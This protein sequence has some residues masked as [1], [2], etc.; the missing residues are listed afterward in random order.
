MTI[1]Q[2]IQLNAGGSMARLSILKMSANAHN[3]NRPPSKQID[4]RKSRYAN[5]RSSDFGLNRGLNSGEPIWYTNDGEQF[6]NERYC[7]EVFSSIRHTGW[8]SDVHCDEKI[9]GIVAMLP[10]NRF[11]AGY[12]S[13]CN[14]E[15][16]YFGEVFTDENDA[17]RMA[18]EHARISA[19]KEMEYSQKFD[20]ANNLSYE[21]DEE[22]SR[23]KEC[24]ALRNDP[25]FRYVRDSI[26]ECIETIRDNRETL[27][28]D[29]KDVL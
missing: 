20:E 12:E 17:S 11:I 4:W 28:N 2:Y 21:I 29:Y 5:F 18:D 13:T 22:I 7:D 9:R 14:D 26:S 19:E 23:L 25:D 1:P 3:I 10:H 8:W 27:E 6:R 15:R 24:I 16:V